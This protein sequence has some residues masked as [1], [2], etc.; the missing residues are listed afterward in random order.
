M[1]PIYQDNASQLAKLEAML[2]DDPSKHLYRLD[3]AVFTDEQLFDLEL[4]Y[5]FEGNW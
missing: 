3:R 4:K 5:I 2:Q 1:I